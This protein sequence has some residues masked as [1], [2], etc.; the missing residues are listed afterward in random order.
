MSLQAY[1]KKS[2]DLSSVFKKVRTKM[3]QTTMNRLS[4]TGK[5]EEEIMS[6]HIHPVVPNCVISN[7]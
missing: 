4:T 3:A 2:V 5:R 1:S 6:K 7:A